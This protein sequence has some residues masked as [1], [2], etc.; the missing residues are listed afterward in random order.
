MR[1]Y[2]ATLVAASVMGCTAAFAADLPTAKAPMAPPP[3]PP[4]SGWQF[5]A[6]IPLWLTAIDGTVGVRQLPSSSVNSSISDN[7]KNLK[8]ALAGD[9]IARNGTFIF[10]LDFMWAK[11]GANTTF[12]T[13]GNGPFA[14][15]RQGT[16]AS[17]TQN[18]VIGTAF[19][20]Y[21]LPIAI[22]NLAVYGTLGARYTGLGLDVNLSRQGL[23][24]PFPG[25]FS[26]DNHQS[27]QW[28]DPVIGLAGKYLINSQWFIDGYADIG[29]FGL[30]SK[31]TTEDTLAVG[32]NWTQ[33]IATSLGFKLI[34]DNYQHNN[35]NGSF[36]YN[37]ATYG[38][39]VNL[40]V[41][42]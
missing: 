7:L 33:N 4:P 1:G 39:V 27:A 3:P 21:R 24:P 10:G 26:V 16:T 17:F 34:Y 41:N 19:V 23:P 25:G 20:G 37:M 15:L 38:P 31:I 28:V 6:T 22:Q 40:S 30:V 32:Y 9:F 14:P 18:S 5:T 2:I 13:S 12:K 35:G 36:R 29:G 42:F 8:A 11:V